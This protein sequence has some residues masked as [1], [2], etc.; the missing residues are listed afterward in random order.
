MKKVKML[1]GGS[2]LAISLCMSVPMAVYA[3]ETD[4]A[5]SGGEETLDNRTDGSNEAKSESDSQITEEQAA[6]EEL[7]ETGMVVGIE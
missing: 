1:L 3:A 5:V 7:T 2:L 6:E 4:T